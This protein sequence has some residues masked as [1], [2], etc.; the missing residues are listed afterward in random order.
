MQ[1]QRGRS[2]PKTKSNWGIK[3]QGHQNSKTIKSRLRSSAAGLLLGGAAS[4]LLAA[5]ASATGFSS[6]VSWTGPYVGIGVGAVVMVTDT[7][8]NASRD[9]QVDVDWIEFQPGS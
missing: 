5:P 9:G 2:E 6:G 4:C 1:Q 8:V 3:M 7:K